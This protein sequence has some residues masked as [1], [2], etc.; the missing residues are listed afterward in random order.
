[1]TI[2]IR[3][4]L[5]L[6]V[7]LGTAS[8]RLHAQN[9]PASAPAAEAPAAAVAPTD[10]RV[11][12]EIDER[13]QQFLED[14]TA[15]LLVLRTSPADSLVRME[16]NYQYLD[17]RW[18]TF[19]QAQQM[20]IATD[21]GLMDL[22]AKYQVANQNVMEEMQKLKGKAESVKAYNDCVALLKKQL[23]YYKK[24]YKEAMALTLVPKLAPKLEQLK[25]KEQLTFAD[26]Q[27]SFEKAKEALAA[28]PASKK[29]QEK[30]EERYVRLKNISDKIQAAEYKPLLQR[31]KDELMGLAC[32]AILLMFVSMLVAR[33]QAIKN[34]REA[35]KKYGNMLNNNRQYP[36][37]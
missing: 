16:H 15:L 11:M 13:L 36:T 24:L 10:E 22:V 37:I 28:N 27:A 4:I 17:S 20:D 25:G 19:Y 29:Q 30:L 34:A 21:E 7:L 12:Q 23:P 9:A 31:A 1:M 5:I 3:R 8:F 26:I 14:I 32:I 18:Q 33:L 35:A 6:L 2:T